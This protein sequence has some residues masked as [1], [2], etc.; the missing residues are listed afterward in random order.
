VSSMTKI[1]I[2]VRAVMAKLRSPKAA[3]GTCGYDNSNVRPHV[4]QI[5]ESAAI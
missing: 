4:V 2:G 5:I 1:V 3:W